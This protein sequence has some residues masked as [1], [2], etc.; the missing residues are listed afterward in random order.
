MTAPAFDYIAA[1]KAVLASALPLPLRMVALVL[2]EHMPDCHP[3]VDRLA[4]QCGVERKTVMRALSKLEARG[5]I[6]VQRAT[7]R[8]SRYALQ[9]VDAW[10]SPSAAA[11]SP[12]GTR[13]AEAPVP[14][15]GTGTAGP[16]VTTARGTGTNE[17]AGPVPTKPQTSPTPV[18]KAVLSGSSKRSEAGLPPPRFSPTPAAS[19]THT[20]P[21][22]EPSETYLA[23]CVMA[24]VK[25]DQARSTWA[26][27]FGAGLPLGGVER[28]EWWLVQ[29]AKE[30][31]DQLARAPVKALGSGRPGDAWKMGTRPGDDLDTTGA[32]TAFRPNSDH[33]DFARAHLRGKDVE[34]LAFKC[35]QVPRFA[36]LSGAKR[37]AEF[38]ARLKSYAETGMF[39]A[40]GPLPRLHKTPPKDGNR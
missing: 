38:L 20:M 26:H 31:Q 39:M 10:R 36:A 7:G 16:P 30:R 17:G 15:S 40:D 22:P 14:V 37:D 23:D 2:V 12:T 33:R 34:A 18:P 3:S 9:P 32:A 27:Y 25:P 4:Q 5:V 1:R 29:R 13:D 24:G 6:T 19:R 21:G 8:R 11:P 35:R 28:L